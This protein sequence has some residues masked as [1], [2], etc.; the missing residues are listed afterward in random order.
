MQKARDVLTPENLAMLQLIADTGSFA[1]AAR[2]LNLV[3]SALTYR[4]RQIEDA[5]DVLLFDRSARQAHPTPAGT[6]LLLEGSRLL[7]D[8]DAIANHVRRVATGWEPQLTLSVDQV[9]STPTMLELA[10]AFYD[11]KPTPPTRLKFTDGILSGTLES[12]TSGVADLAIGVAIDT[13]NIAGLQASPMGTLQFVFV[14]APHHPL[15]RTEEPISDSVLREHR[16]IAVAD[17]ARRSNVT[18]GILPGQDVMTVDSMSAKIQA[19][20]RG[21]GAGFLPEPMVRS[22]VQAGLLVARSVQRPQ[23]TVRMSYVWGRSSHGAPGQALKWWLEQ[24]K[25]V[26]TQRSLLENHHHF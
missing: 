7:E 15:A 20:L 17:S 5:L 1:A 11:V 2:E 6:E 12:L 10:E 9:I 13:P 19:Q 22:Y 26:T 4:V 21:L 14:V 23:R 18:M 3:P 8:V 24:L 16:L 25:S